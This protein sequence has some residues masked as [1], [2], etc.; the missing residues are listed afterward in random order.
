MAAKVQ[1]LMNVEVLAVMRST[2][3]T[4]GLTAMLYLHS[5]LAA[6]QLDHDVTQFASEVLALFLGKES[7]RRSGDVPGAQYK[8]DVMTAAVTGTTPVAVRKS[9]ISYETSNESSNAK[10]SPEGR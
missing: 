2:I 4:A 10:S 6:K 3:T 8:F 7:L 5:P 9:G 1:V